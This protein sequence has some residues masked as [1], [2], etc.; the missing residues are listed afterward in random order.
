VAKAT[1]KRT[2]ISVERKP[3]RGKKTFVPAE[4]KTY[5]AT[6]T[7]MT[8]VSAGVAAKRRR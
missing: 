3:V 2:F 7:T 5:L 4:K 6:K 8:E 1:V